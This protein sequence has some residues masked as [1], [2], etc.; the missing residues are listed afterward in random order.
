MRL[1]HELRLPIPPGTITYPQA[2]TTIDLVWGNSQA[3]NNILK[4]QIATN[5][6]HGS[7]HYS[8]ETIIQICPLTIEPEEPP[9]NYAKTNWKELKYN[10]QITLPELPK[11]P[12]TTANNIDSYMQDL[13]T[14]IV[15]AI[16]AT[17]P[18]K[19]PAPQS[20]RWWNDA[21]HE[22][23]IETNRW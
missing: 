21:L 8:I 4:C 14:T 6:D 10:L 7:D 3:E 11:A 20:K 23:R 22:M 2:D 12:P 18:R 17:T 1:T 19:R 16:L 15:N 5:S 13:S 9:L